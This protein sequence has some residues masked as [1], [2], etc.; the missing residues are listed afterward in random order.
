M[1]KH[2]DYAAIYKD[3]VECKLTSDEICK[4]YGVMKSVLDLLVKNYAENE[5]D[6]LSEYTKA[7]A[8]RRK[9]YKKKQKEDA[10]KAEREHE[11]ERERQNIKQ[12]KYILNAFL[13]SELDEASFCSQ[14]KMSVKYFEDKLYEIKDEDRRLYMSVKSKFYTDYAKQQKQKYQDIEDQKQK[15]QI[16]E[17]QDIMKKYMNS[18]TSISA[19]CKS[20]NISKSYFENSVKNL[21]TTEPKLYELVKDKLTDDVINSSEILR[22]IVTKVTYLTQNGVTLPSGDTRNFTLFDYYKLTN[23]D[24]KNLVSV[25]KKINMETESEIL[26]NYLIKNLELTRK[27]DV[28]KLYEGKDSDPDKA[29]IDSILNYINDNNLPVIVG[30]YNEVAKKFED[31]KIKEKENKEKNKE[32]GKDEGKGKVQEKENRSKLEPK[33]KMEEFIQKEFEIKTSDTEVIENAMNV[34]K[35]GQKEERLKT[36]S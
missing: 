25:A 11:L 35:Y 26:N 7:L 27:V 34:I 36:K 4:K 16:I 28:S 2:L 18:E 5:L 32:E 20:N 10:E 22:K 23:I 3:Y 24:F 21:R 8:V 1:K 30:V 19:F 15:A 14:E 12:A 29:K 13:D 6:D 33:P 17:A 31:M 9:L